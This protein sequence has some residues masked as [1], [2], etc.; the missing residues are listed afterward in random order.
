MKEKRERIVFSVFLQA[1]FPPQFLD[2]LKS[3]LGR[4]AISNKSSAVIQPNRRSITAP[5]STWPHASHHS[6]SLC[7]A[8]TRRAPPR[9]SKA[10]ESDEAGMLAY[11]QTA[12]TTEKRRDSVKSEKSRGSM[13]VLGGGGLMMTVVWVMG[14]E[15]VS[16]PW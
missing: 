16:R 7:T 9:S 8:H 2:T 1:P 10:A 14:K 5:A 12:R 13:P 6:S 15:T 3:L 11:G 4:I